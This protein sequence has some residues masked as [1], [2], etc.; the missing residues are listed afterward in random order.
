MGISVFSSADKVNWQ[1]QKPVFDAP[2]AWAVNAIPGFKGH[3]WAPDI[4]Y[5]NGIYY[6]Y[7]S[8]S[9]FGKNTSCI[10]VATNTTLDVQ[11]KDFIG[12]IMVRYLNPF[13][14]EICGM[15]SIRILRL[16]SNN[17]PWLTFGSFWSGIKLVKLS[18]NLINIAQPEEWYTIAKRA[19]DFKTRDDNAG[20]AAIE[21]PF[22]FK[23]N[24]YY[25]LFASFDFWCRGA[26]GTYRIVAGRPDKIQ[27]P[28]IDKA[29]VR[30]D[31]G[32]GTTILQGNAQWPGVGHNATYTIDGK[33][34]IL[35]HA[36]D[37]ADGGKP[38]PKITE[39][40]WSADGWPVVTLP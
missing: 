12:Q 17:K 29:G 11:S 36:Y 15:L 33:D 30:M 14:A 9:A 5:H 37:A 6:L 22:I 10:G 19:R 4:A 16:M 21:A 3:I 27:G 13:P 20:E 18:S 26:N 2:P 8:V 39:I 34:Y 35:F 32:D 25:Y 31:E 28:Y 7:Y 24:N 1:P 23:M 40:I 38:K